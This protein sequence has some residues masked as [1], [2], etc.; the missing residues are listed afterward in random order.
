MTNLEKAAELLKQA[1]A[2][3]SEDKKDYD[4]LDYAAS[5]NV[6]LSSDGG[7]CGIL[8]LIEKLK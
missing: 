1:A 7:E 6:M 8:P 4:A 5:I 2:I 3:L